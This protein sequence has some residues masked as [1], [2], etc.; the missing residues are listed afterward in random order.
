MNN[1]MFWNGWYGYMN[2]LPNLLMALLVLLIGWIIAKLIG[3]GVEKALKKT[4]A[5]NRFFSKAGIG[6]EKYPPEKIV[7]K[8]IYYILL[9]FVFILFFNVLNLT[10]I[11]SPLVSMFTTMT[12][13]I[14]NVLKAALILL[15][16]WIAASILKAIIT[17]GGAKLKVSKW[18]KKGNLADTD[19]Q[20]GRLVESAGKVVFYLVLLMFIP[21]VLDALNIDGIAGPFENMLDSFLAF[22]PKL[23][24]AVIVLAIGWL[25][26]K[27]VR[28]L[29]TNLLSAV[30][31]D[32]Y[33]QKAGIG[34]S[35]D[36]MSLAS[37]VGTVVYVLILIP[38][39]ITALERL[40]LRGVSEPAINMLNRVLEMIPNIIVAVVLIMVGIWVAKWA[41]KF[42]EELLQ[43]AGV[44]SL[45]KN[46]HLGSWTADESSMTP[47][48]LLSWI[49][50]IFIIFLFTV[51]A[52]Q[53]INLEFL[54]TLALGIVSYLPSVIAAVLILA[55]GIILGN[56]VQ[57]VLRNVLSG[58]DF[59]LLGSVAKYAV[60]IFALFMA[61]DQLG[62]ADSIVNTAFM[63]I[64]GGLALAFGLAFG[65][66]GK[67]TAAKYLRQL[68]SKID[69]T[70]FS[71]V[72]EK[73][74][75]EKEQM[76]QEA[77]T[78]ANEIKQQSDRSSTAPKPAEEI[79]PDT[80]TQLFDHPDSDN[81]SNPSRTDLRNEDW[82]DDDRY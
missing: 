2:E 43:K 76:K 30:G 47:A 81:F 32:R 16:G 72:K 17:K 70:D 24:S 67:E 40:E 15:I 22:I 37:I 11:A 56:I 21:G 12:S 25:A 7:G 19:A 64:L 39:V 52:L 78:K 34:K 14:P 8:V 62:V 27:I 73:A 79:K 48:K 74:K 9:I 42:T 20:A 33:A 5:D 59:R 82:E 55:V 45:T 29:V 71:E 65:L 66:G 75:Q 36:S 57:R 10:I 35:G 38:V 46:L 58:S 61:L 80:E 41:A 31:I 13:F 6:S 23:F 53:I 60:I 4:N 18:M 1:N 50:Q 69:D 51:E 54:V 3:S 49:V 68:D 77:E 26:A 44:N 63:L 28:D